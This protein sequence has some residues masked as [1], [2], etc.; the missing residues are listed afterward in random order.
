MNEWTHFF[1]KNMYL[2]H[3][4]FRCFAGVCEM[5]GDRDRL[6]YWPN[7]FLEHSTLCYLLAL[8]PHLGWGCST[9]GNWGPQPSVYLL[10]FTLAFLSPTNSTAAGTCLYSFITSS[11]FRFFFRLFTQVHLSLTARSR[12]IIQQ[13]VKFAPIQ[14]SDQ[15]TNH[16]DSMLKLSL[17]RYTCL[18]TDISN[19][20][21]INIA[22]I[23]I[24]NKMVDFGGSHR[25]INISG[26]MDKSDT[27][28]L[29]V[30]FHSLLKNFI[31]LDIYWVFLH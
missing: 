11:C 23:Y 24:Y 29:E 4:F 22:Y 9:G 26:K 10:V 28:N 30:M 27:P 7:F 8:L 31:R 16:Q 21:F 1:I 2:S 5:S 3:F 25:M 18:I 14:S 19:C 15:V 20:L 12:V 13:T 17:L 6:L